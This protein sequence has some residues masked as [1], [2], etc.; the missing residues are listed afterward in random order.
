LADDDPK[1]YKGRMPTDEQVLFQLASG[2]D[3]M[4]SKDIIHRN[5]RPESILISASTKGLQMK[6]TGFNFSVFY[7]PTNISQPN[8]SEWE[9][10]G[11][12]NWAS[13]EDKLL[14]TKFTETT[15]NWNRVE[16]QIIAP[17]SRFVHC[18]TFSFG[19]VFL[20]FLLRGIHPFGSIN[21][22]IPT[23]IAR[24]NPVNLKGTSD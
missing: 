3:Y 5:I 4:H 7:S 9:S 10:R 8:M 19:C 2:L 15:N 11:R 12:P 21:L 24:G 1:K 23:N 16:N 6:I 20:Y 14:I 18:D 13:P 17:K 22:V